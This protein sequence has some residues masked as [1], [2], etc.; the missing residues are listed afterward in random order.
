M[1]HGRLRASF[2]RAGPAVQALEAGDTAALSA[3]IAVLRRYPDLRVAVRSA[4]ADSV[5][6]GAVLEA[7]RSAGVGP[8]EVE[9][10]PGPLQARLMRA[11]GPVGG[12]AGGPAGR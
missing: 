1:G 5:A 7:L 10:G 9:A 4:E 8:I 11:G 3:L 6:T 12:P 2:H